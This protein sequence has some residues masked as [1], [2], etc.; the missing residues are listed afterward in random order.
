MYESERI[1]AGRRAFWRQLAGVVIKNGDRSREGP[2]L[3]LTDIPKLPD[4]VVEE[5][6][7]VWMEGIALDIRDD[8]IYCK[9]PQG[10]QYLAHVFS[11]HEKAMIDQYAC[12][13]NL[14]T[15]AENVAGAAGLPPN[16][17]FAAARALFEELCEHGWC[18]PAAVHTD[19]EGDQ[20]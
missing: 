14:Y 17:A 8:G 6:I 11:G 1:D 13:R 12:G 10:E 3:L 16:E 7:P 19:V 18:H 9:N 2:E 4:A 15:I 20:R 5:M